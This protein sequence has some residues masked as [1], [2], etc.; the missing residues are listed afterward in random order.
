MPYLY[1]DLTISPDKLKQVVTELDRNGLRI[2]MHCIGDK[3]SRVALDAVEAARAANGQTDLRHCIT[4]GFFLSDEDIPRFSQ[5]R[6]SLSFQ[7]WASTDFDYGF[8]VMPII[9]EER[10]KK[11]FP[12]KSLINAGA[13]LTIGSDWPCVTASLNP[14]PGLVMA[15]TRIDPWY[16]ERGVFNDNEKLTMEELVSMLTIHGAELMGVDDISG[17]IEEGKSADLVVLDR[18]IIECSVEKLAETR[19]LL[20]LLE[21]KAVYHAQDSPILVPGNGLKTPDMWR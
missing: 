2:M 19:A 5:L 21:G 8:V 6:V 13:H 14:F 9:G 11:A 12:Y 18:N 10:W 3:G 15:S 20:T 7:T 17:S 1:G 16:P 4:H